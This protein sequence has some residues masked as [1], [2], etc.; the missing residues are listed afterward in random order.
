PEAA[1]LL[2]AELM[3][4][5]YRPRPIAMGTNTD[6][7]QP[8]E[9]KLEITRSILAVLRETHHPCTIVTKSNLILRDIDILA[10]MAREHL[11]KV[12]LSVTT[13]DR[14]IARMMEPRAATPERRIDAIRA[15]SEAGIP[16]S[17]MVAPII[18][19]LTDHEMES[20]LERAASA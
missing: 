17:V 5:S 1:Q 4:K 11:V 2:R 6:P 7:Y 10:D 19:S 15:L 3:A 8:T 14:K 13:L 18:P 20:I 9:R 12:A 16:A